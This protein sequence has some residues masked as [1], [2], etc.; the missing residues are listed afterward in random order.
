MGA[1]LNQ[2][3]RNNE[4]STSRHAAEW[5]FQ[6]PRFTQKACR[7]IPGVVNHHR[8]LFDIRLEDYTLIHFSSFPTSTSSPK[9]PITLATAISFQ[10]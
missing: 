6:R 5:T 4:T 3:I 10:V 2:N 7:V 9:P 1:L 8:A